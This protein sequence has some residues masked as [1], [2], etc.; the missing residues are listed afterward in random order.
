ML[1]SSKMKKKKR[2]AVS[3][4]VREMQT[5]LANKFNASAFSSFHCHC[6]LLY[7]RC[8][9]CRDNEKLY[10]ALLTIFLAGS[11]PQTHDPKFPGLDWATL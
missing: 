6:S 2:S 5:T 7:L 8:I 10:L 9:K 4:F 1:F 3:K 11:F